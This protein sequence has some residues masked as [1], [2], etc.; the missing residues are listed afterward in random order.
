MAAQAVPDAPA[1]AGDD[2]WDDQS[3][4]EYW[5]DIEYDTDGYNDH[6]PT[7]NEVQKKRKSQT[8]VSSKGRKR[9]A[10][11]S[12]VSNLKKR[13][14]DPSVNSYHVL[15]PVL[16]LDKKGLEIR[17]APTIEVSRLLSCAMLPDW[18]DKFVNNKEFAPF[19]EAGHAVQ[20]AAT[21][22]NEE[23]PEGNVEEEAAI[24][25]D[26]MKLALQRHL[27]SLGVNL[28]NT[29]ESMLLQMI[30]KMMAGEADADD[31]MDQLVD[32]IHGES[33]DVKQED[34]FAGW[35]SNQI[36]TKE[37]EEDEAQ[38]S[39]GALREPENV[40]PNPSVHSREAS[41]PI[42]AKD[43]KPTRGM[44]RNAES[45][46]SSPH[47]KSKYQANQTMSKG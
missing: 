47:K 5:N 32:G 33:D 31:L 46:K 3:R 34:T 23:I 38:A 30:E 15:P 9:R 36:T 45:P 27:G 4:Y 20:A 19:S 8:D 13:K 22:E 42:S 14:L 18:R 12:P 37:E 7:T 11:N 2:F 26:A 44:K 43:S 6:Q 16:L 39:V 41:L 28:G 10:A 29:D 17:D 25:A 21:E 24:S 35:V 40:Q 1:F